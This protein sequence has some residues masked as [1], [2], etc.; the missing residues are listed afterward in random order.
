MRRRFL[1]RA[2]AEGVVEAVEVSSD[3]QRHE[4]RQPLYT[5]RYMEG[6]VSPV[7]G[8]D[9]GSRAK[10]REHMRAHGLVDADDFKGEWDKKAA[11]RER[12]RRT[13][14]DGK[15]WSARFQETQER[16]NHGRR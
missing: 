7:D 4:E 14:D 11:E 15:D 10:R 3:Y 5:D 8:S 6:T 2:N 16:L 1:Y 12:F 9:I 13:G